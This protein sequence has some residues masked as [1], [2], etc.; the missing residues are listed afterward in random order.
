MN[1]PVL[2][3]ASCNRRRRAAWPQCSRRIL[4]RT[5]GAP[6]LVVSSGGTAVGKGFAICFVSEARMALP[7]PRARK[8]G[9]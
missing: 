7:S 1:C 8:P 2:M 5:N 6:K 9:R 4:R 3:V